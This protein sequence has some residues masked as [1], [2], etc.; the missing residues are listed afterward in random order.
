MVCTL[1]RVAVSVVADMVDTVSVVDTVLADMVGR[2]DT[3]LAVP[4]L[5]VQVV[6]EASRPMG[7][8]SSSP[9]CN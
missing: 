5:V 7:W 8:G 4:D 1:G 6:W 9:H 3:V 2:V